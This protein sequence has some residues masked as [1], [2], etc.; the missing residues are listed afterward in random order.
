M[1]FDSW[2]L[3]FFFLIQF[4]FYFQ[5]FLV[6]LMGKDKRRVDHGAFVAHHI[7]TMTLI[8]GSYFLG[9]TRSALVIFVLHDFSDIFVRLL[10]HIC[11]P[12]QIS[13]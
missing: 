5:G 1:P 3:R 7:I 9:W 13:I 2:P 11:L 4:A 12:I 10:M 8:G 6:L